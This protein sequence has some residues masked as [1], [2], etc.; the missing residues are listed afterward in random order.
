MTEDRGS[1]TLPVIVKDALSAVL[2]VARMRLSFVE[3]IPVS[4]WFKIISSESKRYGVAPA[5]SLLPPLGSCVAGWC[6]VWAVVGKIPVV[7]VCGP[8]GGIVTIS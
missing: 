7:V 2:D 8:F 5:V 3:C 1:E 6:F 4:I